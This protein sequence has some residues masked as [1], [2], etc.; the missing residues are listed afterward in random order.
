[1]VQFGLKERVGVVKA[2]KLYGDLSDSTKAKIENIV[3]DQ[4][5]LDYIQIAARIGYKRNLQMR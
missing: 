5:K 2:S 3:K 4:F 1:M